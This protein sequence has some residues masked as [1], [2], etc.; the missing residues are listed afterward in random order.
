MNWKYLAISF[1]AIVFTM[2]VVYVA[3]KKSKLQKDNVM[4]VDEIVKMVTP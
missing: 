3:C 1:F 2:S 4:F